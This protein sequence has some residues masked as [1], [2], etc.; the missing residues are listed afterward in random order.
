MAEQLNL[1]DLIYH[2]GF[3]NQDEFLQALQRV[4]EQA[5]AKAKSG[6]GAGGREF[7]EAFENEAKKALA[8]TGSQLV[9]S[10]GLD[11]VGVFLGN[12]LYNAFQ[13][14]LGA[15]KQFIGQSVNEFARY[16]QGLVQLRLAGEENLG[17]AAAKIKEIA[18]A[19]KVFSETDV[20]LT[21]GE[22][23]KA[24]FDASTA[25]EL[26]AKSTNLASA[27]I[28]TATGKFLDLTSSAK[29]VSDILSGLDYNVSQAGRVIDV[30]G[31]TSQDSKLSLSDL[32][33][34]IASVAGTARGVGLE[35][36][37]LGATFAALK[38]RGI[39]AA[40]A[41]TGLRSV[42]NSLIQPPATAKDAFE[43]LG[44][45]F[46]KADGSTRSYAEVLQNLN[47]VVAAG[48][49]GVQLLAQGMDTFALNTAV[50]LGKSSSAIGDFKQ[51]LENASG[52]T[53]ELGNTLKN[54][55]LGKFQQLEAEIAN[56]RREIGQ[57]LQ[58]AIALFLENVA[59][60]FARWVGN[61][62]AG[63]R[64]ASVSVRDY[65]Q[66]IE[67]V[68][69]GTA[70]INTQTRLLREAVQQLEKTTSKEGQPLKVGPITVGRFFVTGSL[71]GDLKLL[72]EQRKRLQEAEAKL[73]AANA[74]TPP[75]R[76]EPP[77]SPKPLAIPDEDPVI[78]Q[79]RELQDQL[80]ILQYRYTLGRLSAEQYRAELEKLQ[81]QLQALEK[82][83]TT[84][85]R[86]SAVL[87]GL[88]DIRK[89]LEDISR[90]DFETRI[91]ALSDELERQKRLFAD[92]R[93]I[94]Q[95]AGALA[96]V[97]KK[98]QT[99][100][101]TATTE[102]AKK[103]VRELL[104]QIATGRKELQKTLEEGGTQAAEVL[105][106]QARA[107]LQAIYGDG[108]Q[109][110]IA[111]VRRSYPDFK[112]AFEDL[113]KDG[114]KFDDAQ[115]LAALAFPSSFLEGLAETWG[116]GLSTAA[117]RAGERA[118]DEFY[119][120][121]ERLQKQTDAVLLRLRVSEMSPEELLGLSPQLLEKYVKE[122]EQ[123]GIDAENEIDRLRTAIATLTAD[124]AV[125]ERAIRE[126]AEYGDEIVKTG[127]KVAD[128][129]DYARTGL[130]EFRKSLE[131]LAAAAGT[132]LAA[133]QQLAVLEGN[134]KD[135]LALG[136]S[137][138]QEAERAQAQLE[139]LSGLL[140]KLSNS[141]RVTEAP[142]DRFVRKQ[143][144]VR[145]G[146]QVTIEGFTYYLDTLEQFAALASNLPD[147]AL[148]GLFSGLEAEAERGNEQA[149]ALLETLRQII[150]ARG[151]A[152]GEAPNLGATDYRKLEREGYGMDQGREAFEKDR[153]KREDDA[154]KQLEQFE[155]QLTDI[156]LSFPKALV[157][158]ILS[159]DVAGALKQALGSATDFFLNKMLEAILGPI[160]EEFSKVIAKQGLGAA[161]GGSSILGALGPIG[162]AVGA[163]LLLFDFLFNKP[164]PASEKAAAERSSLQSST[165]SITYNVEA[166]LNAT[167]QGD[168][169][170]PATR[171]ELRGL[172]RQVALD[173]LKEVQ[174]VK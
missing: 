72:E 20:S 99:L 12:A 59:G 4:L 163:G 33:P 76:K 5:E 67:A 171:A 42:I 60:P 6:G 87:G 46:I 111:A 132:P 120:I 119:Q 144:E 167:L 137:S 37:D 11:A 121:P 27:E 138:P 165:P 166:V 63:F 48:P 53:E 124:P 86:K 22:L 113:L 128:G 28:D 17:A 41:A 64:A 104:D 35:V 51:N 25:M 150:L 96:S 151:Q 69:N 9:R 139:V 29:S 91:K 148:I 62:A 108:I 15:T 10:L 164:Q 16:E 13:N 172:M 126:S 114:L 34:A 140:D 14:A 112:S 49:R 97:E 100:G 95:Y 84:T 110:T 168:L 52:A 18:E 61:I 170:D 47:R 105:S 122:L 7:G 134:L 162:L 32:V 143:G 94:N 82:A 146:L 75:P 58:P 154:Q 68:R 79:A 31:K 159:G 73:Q 102:Q 54:T 109:A 133:I 101:K 157:S 23:V 40:E 125:I 135:A 160:A 142:L 19:S 21:L 107:R 1:G 131:A 130:D 3:A 8:G 116:E 161:L 152:F 117:Q 88:T 66:E 56:T 98:A 2:L 74:K 57:N 89:T 92:T 173:V 30:L 71:E 44:L 153:Q 141:L 45:V 115:M 81:R 106:E 158:G 136:F 24:G 147:D 85:E 169:K 70:P 55:A 80:K 78:R 65:R 50:A 174:L 43:K 156:A 129:T 36:E 118:L 145:D 26:T 93:D 77:P 155:A 123:Y 83:A 90:S 103:S 149:R 39:P 38:D 127:R